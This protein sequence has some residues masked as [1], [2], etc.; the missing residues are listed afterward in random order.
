MSRRTLPALPLVTLMAA[1]VLASCGEQESSTRLCKDAQ[2]R[3]TDDSAC[4][5]GRAGHGFVFIPGMMG[6][7]GRGEQISGYSNS[8]GNGVVRTA[9]G[10]TVRGGFGMSARGDSGS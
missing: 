3:R 10:R 2:G 6:L 7:P 9:E 5:I 4:E 8:A 1:A